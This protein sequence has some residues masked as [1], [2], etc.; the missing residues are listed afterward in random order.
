MN[1][2][3]LEKN[4]MLLPK[5]FKADSFSAGLKKN[6]APDM[7][8]IFSTVNTAAAGTFT[9][10]RV[11]ASCVSRNEKLIKQSGP[12]RCIIVNSGNANAC[13]GIKGSKDN[14][15]IAEYVAERLGIETDQVLT[16]STG[17]IGVELPMPEIEKAIKS[18]S[19]P[20][21][22]AI[23]GFE[24]ASRAILT[25]DLSEKK[26]T[27]KFT[28]QEKEVT[29][30]GMAKGSGM[31]HPNMATMLAFIT[32][33]LAISQ[34]LLMSVLQET[35][36]DTFNMISVDGDTSTNDM[37]L[38]M[39]NGMAEN[40]PVQ[41]FSDDFKQFKKALK[42]V[43]VYLAQSIAADGEGAT[44]LLEVEVNGAKSVIDA[45]KIAKA[46]ITSNLVKTAFFGMDP[47]WGR[48]IAAIG[49]SGAN[50]NPDTVSIYFQGAPGYSCLMDHGT[51]HEYDRETVM[52]ILKEKNIIITINLNDGDSSA[53]AWG[54]DLSYDY[55]KINAEYTT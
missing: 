30:T 13:T 54:C 25:T 39:A 19:L 55:V 37:V 34:S 43:C 10:N 22:P 41:S 35:V 15:R 8:V 5:G 36:E 44:K 27:L 14:I 3:L 33:D 28:V 11:R 38:M 52:G 24:R 53:V 32:T 31:I 26:V 16:A 40:N 18:F 6:N 12:I 45:K 21:T 23:E 50:F 29:I 7:A 42:Q 2:I 48:I 47:N 20:D 4:K 1:K 46:V 17:V 9:T 49:Y 51:P